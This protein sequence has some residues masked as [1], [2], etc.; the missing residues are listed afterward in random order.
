METQR[1][2]RSSLESATKLGRAVV[3]NRAESSW[4]LT[5]YPGAAEA[6]G[7][8]VSA[9][10]PPARFPVEPEEDRAASEATR[11]ARGQIRRYCAANRLNRLGTLTYRG[12][13]CFDARQ[14]R[15]DLGE[16]FRRLR[17]DLGQP[18]PYLW[19]PE[20][21]PGGHGLHAHFAVG[22]YIAQRR[23][24]AAW[25]QGFVHIKQ[26]SDLA[27]GSG[28]LG[29]A[30]LGAWYLAKY[31]GKD[32]GGASGGLHRYDVGQGFGPARKRLRG[33]TVED[34]LGQASAVMGGEP[35]YVW[36]SAAEPVWN[37]PHSVWARWA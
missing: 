5:L 17:A 22:R 28:S 10:R 1:H 7:S 11:R 35:S 9:V 30:R 36:D 24:E 25:G 8:L 13:G 15:G 32:L 4:L 33:P 27:V 19:V 34:V 29:E 37:R 26:L 2:T 23:I 3:P 16:L 14:L 6:G 20:W 21:H 18:F 12:D 31:I